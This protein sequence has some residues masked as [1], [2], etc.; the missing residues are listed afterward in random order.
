[1]KNPIIKE[2]AGD[3][4]ILKDGNDYY[5]T[6]TGGGHKGVNEFV[7]WHSVNLS[8]WSEP[9]TILDLADVSWAKTN[10]WAPL[11]IFWESLL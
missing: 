6:A 5:M 9:V 2:K 7:C 11:R 8:D 1:M 10:G 4:Y 3:P